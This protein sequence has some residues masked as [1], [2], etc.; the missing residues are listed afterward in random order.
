[1]GFRVLHCVASFDRGA[2]GVGTVV[3]NLACQQARNCGLDVA[4]L[5]IDYSDVDRHDGTPLDVPG[6]LVSRE[7]LVGPP[8]LGFSPWLHRA[9]LGSRADV[10]HVHGMWMYMSFASA[11]ASRRL[12]RRYVVSPHGMLDSWAL[13]RNPWRKRLVSALL[14]KRH[15]GRAGC[16]HALSE[17]EAAM[18]RR[19]GATGPICVV[20][21]G[22]RLPKGHTGLPPPWQDRFPRGRKVALC[23]GRLHPKKGL[24]NLIKGFHQATTRRGN[25]DWAVAIAG[26]DQDGH[27]EELERLVRALEVGGQVVVLGPQ[28]EGEATACFEN[29]AAFVLPSFSEGLPMVI[30]EAWSHGLPVVMTRECNIADG[31]DRDAAIE[32]RPT[33]ESVAAGL[34]DLFDMSPSERAAMG[35]RGRSLVESQFTW[36]R[37]AEDLKKVYA[38]VKGG[39]PPPMSVLTT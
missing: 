28:H 38:W 25:T 7:P 4:V 26:W 19:F 30:L 16:L 11:V 32:V 8:Q 27:R 1:M 18:I 14:E 39:G 24:A 20:P 13:Q 37:V 6:V 31:F 15:I 29:A 33:P 34:T 35:A 22:V 9:I 36:T 23:L 2:G 10:W 21:N 3:K 17:Q 12:G 5:T